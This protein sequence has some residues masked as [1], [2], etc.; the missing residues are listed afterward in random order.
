MFICCLSFLSR[1]FFS[2]GHITAGWWF[3]PILCSSCE[4]IKRAK[5]TNLHSPCYIAKY[6]R[7]GISTQIINQ[8]PCM[9]DMICI[10]NITLCWRKTKESGMFITNMNKYIMNSEH[11]DLLY[12]FVSCICLTCVYS[13]IVR[14]QVGWRWFKVFLYIII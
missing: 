2:Y 9:L 10:K 14:Q 1:I 13:F 5:P 3:G 8:S 12:N 7:C 11:F 4:G 6:C